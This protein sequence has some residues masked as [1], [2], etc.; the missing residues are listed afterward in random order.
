MEHTRISSPSASSDDAV[1]AKLLGVAL[2]L[3]DRSQLLGFIQRTINGKQKALILSGNIYSFNLAYENE[4]LR[5]FFN[6]ADIVRLDGAGVRLGA[7]FLGYD[8]PQRMTWADFIWDLAADAEEHSYTLY[9]L[10]GR[11]GVA[12]KAANVLKGKHP[13]LQIVE[14]RHGYFDK[15]IGNVENESVIEHINQTQPDI[16]LVGFGMPLQ[17]KWLSEN[18]SQINARV[19]MTGGAVFDYI[20]GDLRRGPKWMTDNGMEWLARLLI[21]PSRL[22]RRYILGNPQF[23]WRIIKQKMIGQPK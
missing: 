6:Q 18:L 10:G 23:M 14:A 19:I 8:A 7:R 11:P 16:L 2:S 15:S 13:R 4:W 1:S 5:N 21:E 9:F 3:I 22:W 20:S 12:S 17:E